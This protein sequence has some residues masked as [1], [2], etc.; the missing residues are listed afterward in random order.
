MIASAV[1]VLSVR[2]FIT[3]RVA[4]RSPQDCWPEIIGIDMH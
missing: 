1:L 2:E 3:K 4:A